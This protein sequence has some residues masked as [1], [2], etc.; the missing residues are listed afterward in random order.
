MASTLCARF[1]ALNLAMSVLISAAVAHAD[2]KADAA[3][4]YDRG[5]VAFERGDWAE[6]AR[7]FAE[8]DALLPNPSAL[9]SALRSAQR[10]GDPALVMDLCDR[11]SARS[12]PTLQ[13]LAAEARAEAETKVGRLV[14]HC[15]GCSAKI[16]ERAL[17]LDVLTWLAAGDHVLVVEQ[18]GRTER[19]VVHVDRGATVRWEA[20][21]TQEPASAAPAPPPV[22]P[23][24]PA[25]APSPPS[26]APP[27]PAMPLPEPEREGVPPV[28]FWVGAGLTVALGGVA[29]VSGI[30]TLDK[31]SAFEDGQTEALQ[32]EGMSSQ[33]R[34][35][36]LIFST[37]G[38]GLATAVVG[39]WIV[40]W[41][42]G[43]DRSSQVPTTVFR[44]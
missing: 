4:A 8:A 33:T 35:N 36:V 40:D 2:D 31:H 18:Q 15:N 16:A 38:V 28:V 24:A 13:A 39:L 9:E 5:T 3:A 22:E 19:Y 12:S 32:T 29:A 34:T 43:K 26:A 25:L 1:L 10:T 42:S 7:A 17:P 11:A 21:L 20:P 14:V 30:D 37:L 27:P 41:D 23:P 44:F 6:A